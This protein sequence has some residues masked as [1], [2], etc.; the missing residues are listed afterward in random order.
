[1]GLWAA[2]QHVGSTAGL[3]L[4][5]PALNHK[6]LIFLPDR[7]TCRNPPGADANAPVANLVAEHKKIVSRSE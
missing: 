1:M 5:V 6:R 2:R 7:S 4:G 3:R